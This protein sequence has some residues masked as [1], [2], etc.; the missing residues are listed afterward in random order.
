MNA[1]DKELSTMSQP[2]LSLELQSRPSSP[3]SFDRK[4]L[5]A[6]IPDM[7]ILSSP[8][9]FW[10]ETGGGISSNFG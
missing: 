7:A 4:L 9:P 5:D 10:Q 6:G 1:T 2:K 3:K 8:R